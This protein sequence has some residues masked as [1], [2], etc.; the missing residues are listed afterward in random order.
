MEICLLFLKVTLSLASFLVAPPEEGSNCDFPWEHGFLGVLGSRV[1]LE[2]WDSGVDKGSQ[3]KSMWLFELHRQMGGCGSPSMGPLRGEILLW[4]ALGVFPVESKAK[5]THGCC[6]C[7]PHCC[8][9]EQPLPQ[10]FI[11]S[12]LALAL[13]TSH[14]FLFPPFGFSHLGSALLSPQGHCSHPQCCVQSLCHL[15]LTLLPS[16][17]VDVI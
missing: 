15:P 3:T 17:S 4:E 1:F 16:L 8:L 2:L 13:L 10:G 9:P 5:Q 11:F 14:V 6:L 12:V 7:S